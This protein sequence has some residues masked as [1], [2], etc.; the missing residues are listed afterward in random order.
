MTEEFQARIFEPRSAKGAIRV[1]TAPG[2]GT[3]LNVLLP[4]KL[5][6]AKDLPSLNSPLFNSIPPTILVIVDEDIVRRAATAAL[7]RR[8]YFVPEF[9]ANRRAYA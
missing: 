9:L 3:T 5:S 1:R 6:V 4:A 8:G 7:E 2:K